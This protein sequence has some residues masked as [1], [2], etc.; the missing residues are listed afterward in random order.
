MRQKKLNFDPQTSGYLKTLKKLKIVALG[1]LRPQTEKQLNGHKASFLKPLV[2]GA[3]EI[4]KVF[5]KV[6]KKPEV[7]KKADHEKKLFFRP[8]QKRELIWNHLLCYYLML[9]SAFELYSIQHLLKN[10]KEVTEF[11]S[12]SS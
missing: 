10:G 12:S 2:G 8:K 7:F 5:K 4:A 9:C 1:N 11:C 6:F 3:L